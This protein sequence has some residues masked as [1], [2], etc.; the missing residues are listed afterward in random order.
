[1]TVLG[2]IGLTASLLIVPFFMGLLTMETSESVFVTAVRGLITEW[3]IFTVVSVPCIIAETSLSLVLTVMVILSL[4]F[5]ALG[6]LRLM[7]LRRKREIKLY[8]IKKQLLSKNEMIFLALFLGIVLFQ[9]YKAL[10]YAYEDGDDA[11]YISVAASAAASDTMYKTDAYMGTAASVNYRYALAPFPIWISCLTRIS[12]FK[13]AFIAHTVLPAFLLIVTYVIYIQISK[14]LFKESIEKQYMLLTLL[15]VFFMFENVST[16]TQ[17]TFLLTRARQGK[18]ALANIILPF[19]F[20]MFLKLI[21][22][23]LN[24]K[25][26]EWLMLLITLTSAALTS[27]LGNILAP[28]MILFLFIYTAIK[29]KFKLLPGLAALVI[30]NACMCVLYYLL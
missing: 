30:P 23:D 10:F 6:I 29:K 22:N 12:G 25:A 5:S 4:L 19:L 28:V 8:I 13:T 27:V 21:K 3:A 26:A 18:E 9:L 2:I 1:M 14:L 16:S 17:G 11:Y 24:V 7:I 20:L 15:S